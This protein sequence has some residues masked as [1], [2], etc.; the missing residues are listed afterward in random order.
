[1]LGRKKYKYNPLKAPKPKVWLKLDEEKR[2]KLIEDYHRKEGIKVP[3]MRLHATFNAVV[4]NQAALKNETPVAEA[5][6]RLRME[7]LDRHE[8]IH[9]ICNVLIKHIFD[10]VKGIA[11][12]NANL[13]DAYFE[14]IKKL[15]RQSWYDEFGEKN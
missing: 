8:A 9:A 11:D 13:G 4:E 6:M 1:M 7:G 15:T 10:A 5:I 14:D 12:P 2:I 3:N